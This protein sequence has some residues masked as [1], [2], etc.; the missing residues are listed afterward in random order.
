MF[1]LRQ[2]KHPEEDIIRNFSCHVWKTSLDEAKD[3]QK[4]EGALT[5]PKQDPKTKLWCADPELGLSGFA[6]KKVPSKDLMKKMEQYALDVSEIA[7]F[8]STD[9]DLKSGLDSEDVFRNAK[10]LGWLPDWL[11]SR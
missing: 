10:F 6:F 2:T 9:Y 4:R 11:Q 5:A 8:E 7:V 1:F 3:F